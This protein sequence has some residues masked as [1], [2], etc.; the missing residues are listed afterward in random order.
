MRASFLSSMI[1]A[2]GLI[3]IPV[4]TQ[5]DVF[6]YNIS[7]PYSASVTPE[8]GTPWATITFQD[9]ASNH[10]QMSIDVPS[11]MGTQ[12]ISQLN[13]NFDPSLT[14][15]L[16]TLSITN[17]GG[18]APDSIAAPSSNAY[19]AGP[20]HGFDFE[21]QFET[22]NSGRLTGGAS[23]FFDITGTGLLS[24]MFNFTNDSGQG[25]FVTAV[26]IQ[27]IPEGQESTSVWA[28]EGSVEVPEPTTYV[29]LA[30]LLGAVGFLR[31]RRAKQA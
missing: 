7:N 5:A 21:I 17:T 30:S 16:N 18:T 1:L 15:L 27:N 4:T 2:T 23:S 22:K 24:S 20:A 25:P 31:Y 6:I 10:V 26:H 3:F 9:T 14:S 13:F 29:L 12:F 8:G 19:D 28:S 11:S